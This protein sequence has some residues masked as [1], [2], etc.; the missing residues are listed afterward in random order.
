[1]KMLIKLA[2]LAFVLAAFLILSGCSDEVTKPPL[3]QVDQFTVDATVDQVVVHAGDFVTPHVDGRD[4]KPPYSYRWYE[5]GEWIGVGEEPAPQQMN[6]E[7]FH[8]FLVVGTDSLGTVAQDSVIVMVLP[9]ETEPLS[10]DLDATPAILEAGDYTY[11]HTH[12]VG[13]V[14]PYKNYTFYRDGIQMGDNQVGWFRVLMSE[15]GNFN[16][17]VTV[18]DS[19]GTAASDSMTV[20]VVASNIIEI[21]VDTDLKVGPNGRDD[22]EEVH[23]GQTG[24]GDV[25]VQMRFDTT[26]RRFVV[27]GLHYADGTVSYFTVPDLGTTRP[28]Y[29]LVVLGQVRVE[30]TTTISMR[31]TGSPSKDM[32]KCDQWV[33]ATQ[34]C[35]SLKGPNKSVDG[36]PIIR[37]DK[38]GNYTLIE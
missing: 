28:S 30:P 26:E 1:M 21:C 18:I 34:F 2:T 27:F 23:F 13:G 9:A 29:V 8:T 37:L 3:P 12:V 5:R 10:I 38:E 25:T 4:G 16:F 22:S 31:W 17:R 6:K 15:Q 33:T 7:G 14:Q 20:S 24:T 36:T 11:L 35:L 19:L 32:E